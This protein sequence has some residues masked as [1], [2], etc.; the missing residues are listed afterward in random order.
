MWQ[1]GFEHDER[2]IAS[3][4]GYA[5]SFC[6]WSVHHRGTPENPGLVLALDAVE[7]ATCSGLALKVAAGTEKRTLEYLRERELVSAAY[8]EA[9]LRIDLADGRS[10]DAITYVVDVNHVQYCQGLS[11]EDQATI[12]ANASGGRGPNTEYLY[13]TSSHLAQ[14]GIRDNDLEWLSDR[15][16]KIVGNGDV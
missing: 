8:L 9:E 12:I 13:N 5:R 10:V 1:P 3:L 7:N 2:L 15:V 4:P 14:L 11:Q 16:R 6:M